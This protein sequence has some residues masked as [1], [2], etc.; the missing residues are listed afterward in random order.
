MLSSTYM[1]IRGMS[2]KKTMTFRGKPYTVICNPE[3]THASHASFLDELE[4]C[5]LWFDVKPGDV[6]LDVGAAVGSYTLPALVAGASM[7]YAWS[8]P[9]IDEIPYE[10]YLLML[11]L[12]ENR[13]EDRC[14]VFPEGLW[15]S[16]GYMA[17]LDGPRPPKV[18]LTLHEA[19]SL[20]IG[21]PGFHTVFPVRTLDSVMAA[22]NPP[23]VDWIKIDT[24]GCE[25]DILRGGSET[26]KKWKPKL[27]LENHYHVDPDV[28]QRTA[29]LLVELGLSYEKVGTI[30]HHSISHSLYVPK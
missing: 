26:L 13:Y 27:Y 25:V 5:E 14:I 10:S 19:R 15:S 23:K 16:R 21:Q 28:E 29:D 24:E 4:T 30:P 22:C 6:V 8:P 12:W 1:A 20:V 17:M 18:C 2:A 11:N 9:G 3:P 7:V